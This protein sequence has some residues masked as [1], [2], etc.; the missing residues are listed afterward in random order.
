MLFRSLVTSC[1]LFSAVGCT[2]V[3]IVLDKPPPSVPTDNPNGTAEI[4]VIRTGIAALAVTFGIFIDDLHVG[5]LHTDNFVAHEVPPGTVEMFAGAEARSPARFPVAAN[6]SY[7]F[8][9]YPKAGWW[10]ARVQLE[11]MDPEEGR[12]LRAVC[13]NTTFD[14]P[15]PFPFELDLGDPPAE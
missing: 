2:P 14:E 9:A 7:Y 6:R 15:K 12:E 1:L 4:V 13:A 10:F 8:R 3:P 11:V 5:T